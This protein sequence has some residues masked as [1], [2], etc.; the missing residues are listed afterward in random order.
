MSLTEQKIIDIISNWGFAPDNLKK[1]TSGH[2]YSQVYSLIDPA[3]KRPFCFRGNKGN[4]LSKGKQLTFV[5]AIQNFL[6]NHK[7]IESRA[8]RNINGESWLLEGEYLWE[9]LSWAQGESIDRKQLHTLQLADYSK[10]GAYIGQIHRNL[11]SF[12]Q[13]K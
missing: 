1:I 3:S 10:L 8:I 12:T 2:T 6:Y 11:F 13:E 4:E 9:L 5:H 7:L